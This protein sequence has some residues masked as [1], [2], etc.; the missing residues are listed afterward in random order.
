MNNLLAYSY[1]ILL[2]PLLSF[3]LN[4]LFLGKKKKASAIVSCVA[5]AAAAVYAVALA[6]S[7][8][9]SDATAQIAWQI[10]FLPFTEHFVANVGFLVDPLSA[11]MLSVVTLIAFFVNIYSIGYMRE[12][13]SSGRFF[14]FLSLFA[15]SMLGLVVSTNIF[16][17]FVFW[18]LVGVSSYL[19]IGFW[20]HKP[21]A[22]S[23]SKQA[24]ILTRFADSFFLFGLILVSYTVQSFDFSTLNSISFSDF[25]N[26]YINLGLITVS[27][28][29]ALTF[30]AAM[31]FV[32]G[33]GKSAMF[34]MHI[35]LPNAMEGPTPVSSIIH[36]ATM[37]VAGVYL[38]ARLFPFF[39]GAGNT[40]E[41]IMIVGAFTAIF[42]AVIA[43]TQKD[44]KR[45]LAYS[46]LSQLGYM[47]LSLG[48]ARLTDGS[49]NSLGYTASTFHIFTHAF[50][51]CMLFLVAGSLIH[52]VHTNDLD[53]MGGLRKKMPWTYVSC[54]LACLAIAGIPPFAG[55]F[56]KDEILM[57]TFQSG[58]Y[59]VFAVALFTSALT[60]FYM[61]R[62]F[63][64]AFHGKARSEHTTHAHEDLAMTLPIVA[65]AIPSALA[66]LLTKNL[67]AEKFVPGT[68][69]VSEATHLAHVSWIPFV[70][71]AAAVI[72]ILLA[73]VCYGR[74]K[75]NVARALDTDNRS[76]LYRTIYHKFYFDE[77]YYAIV[78]QF[79]FN[80]LS[81]TARFVEDYVIGSVVKFCTGAVQKA[82][83]LVRAVECGNLPFY[84]GTMVAGILIWYFIGN[85]PF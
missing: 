45:I 68:L 78:R 7:F 39:A 36:S 20:Y 30:G 65:L 34:P 13:Q 6:A 67:F 33:W 29:D 8:F 22:V 4:G 56:S 41:L 72:G 83:A 21:S 63:F 32:G 60:A 57:T 53:A 51:K 74:K 10:R 49:I 46:T 23:A 66:G 79:V 27:A 71:S 25:I 61:F 31:I 3:V 16:Q 52:Q 55:F 42:A 9:V 64:L 26:T 12:D 82:G 11:M 19:L 48:A 76:K 75:T 80:G 43:C 2:F 28:S 18:E 47:M 50:F 15:F 14:S 35:W 84:I 54:L 69:S 81:A 70:A 37:V 62:L 59:V 17:M 40:L 85:L 5:A 1:W 58:H 44:I 24:F 73:F 77:A 38:V